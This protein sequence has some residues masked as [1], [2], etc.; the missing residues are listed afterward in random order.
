MPDKQAPT[1]LMEVGYPEY[2]RHP[3]NGYVSVGLLVGDGMEI[4][5]WTADG[6]SSEKSKL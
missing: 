4:S 6:S 2:V 1:M 3:A 5:C